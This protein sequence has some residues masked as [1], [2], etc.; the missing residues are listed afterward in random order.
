MF[1]T[2]EILEPCIICYEKFDENNNKPFMSTKFV[3]NINCN[4]KYMVHES[5][6]NIWL[7]NCIINTHRKSKLNI[8]CLICASPVHCITH[9]IEN[10]DNILSL[11]AKQEI[12]RCLTCLIIIMIIGLIILACNPKRIH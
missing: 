12:C 1:E 7:E 3:K 2:V 9:K 5:C 10:N 4:C 8:K 11:K 6:M